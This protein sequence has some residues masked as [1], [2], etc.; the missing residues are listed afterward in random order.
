[1]SHSGWKCLDVSVFIICSQIVSLREK[2]HLKTILNSKLEALPHERIEKVM[3]Y[4]ELSNLTL[5]CR[6]INL[7]WDEFI[8][9]VK[10]Y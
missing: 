6:T 1:M 7:F 4:F 10:W 5:E 3:Y 2:R 9:T 8:Q